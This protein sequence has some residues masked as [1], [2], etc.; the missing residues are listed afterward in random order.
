MPVVGEEEP[1]V[2]TGAELPPVETYRDPL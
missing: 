1:E 2:L